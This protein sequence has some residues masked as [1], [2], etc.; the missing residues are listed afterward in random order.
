MVKVIGD[1][2]YLASTLAYNCVSKLN[3]NSR[4]NLTM[5]NDL[6]KLELN[7]KIP[8]VIS[9]DEFQNG[10][11]LTS[12]NSLEL[13]PLINPNKADNKRVSFLIL[14]F[15]MDHF[16]WA[17]P[18]EKYLEQEE[19]T[20]IKEIQAIFSQKNFEIDENDIR[21]IFLIFIDLVNVGY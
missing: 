4:E 21:K 19:K 6:K 2:C 13:S 3:D 18:S 9:A 1:L 20:Y 17:N 5:N 16:Q 11:E 8:Y 7:D 15:L 12:I 10:L 14:D